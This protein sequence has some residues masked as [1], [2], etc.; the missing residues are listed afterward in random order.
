MLRQ[1]HLLSALSV[2]A[3]GLVL[4]APAL[5]Q[6]SGSGAP[7]AAPAANNLSIEQARAA[8]IR[9][10]K[11]VQSGDA[12]A[13]YAQF[14]AE[15]QAITSP[16]LIAATMRTQPK[17]RGFSLL[18]VRSGMESS[19]VEAELDTAAGQRVVFMVLNNQGRL[20]RYYVDRA[21]DDVSAVAKQF[22]VAVSTGNFITAHSFLSPAF[23]RE[24]SP[25]ELQRKWLGLH[26]ITGNFVKVGRVVEAETTPDMRL[27][28]VN[29][30]FNRLSD[31][32]YVILNNQN[33]ITGI[34]FPEEP[35]APA[36]VR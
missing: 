32:L 6:V 18:S 12:N 2:M 13:R 29:V 22:V 19:I 30:D 35:A 14:S 8:A 20:E 27:V 10:L 24:I 33:E 28:L 23:Q 7:A 36:P 26:R 34:D 9:I 17:V 4:Q 21:D 5:A 31:N 3:S 1:L 16:A 15:R 11:A 25:D